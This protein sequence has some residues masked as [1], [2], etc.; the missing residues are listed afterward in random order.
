MFE[1][2]AIRL[3]FFISI[4]IL[5][6]SQKKK[7]PNNVRL[8]SCKSTLTCDRGGGC[9]VSFFTPS[10]G[11]PDCLC[12]SRGQSVEVLHVLGVVR[13]RHR[14]FAVLLPM[15]D[16]HDDHHP[17]C[18]QH[19]C[20]EGVVIRHLAAQGA[21]GQ[22]VVVE[23]RQ[24]RLHESSRE[25][26]LAVRVEVVPLLTDDQ[27]EAEFEFVPGPDEVAEILDLAQ[28]PVV[29]PGDLGAGGVEN[30]CG[31]HSFYFLPG[32]Y[33]LGGAKNT[34]ISAFLCYHK[35]VKKSILY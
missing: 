31:A 27:L 24:G 6:S 20:H 23:R 18:S 4:A 7:R 29:V 32:R 26:E 10:L 14:D 35:I 28:K 22:L 21:A 5:I 25:V 13:V 17:L 2:R 12:L 8:S 33:G 30:H 34:D 19:Q 16:L 11:S 9:S 15:E 1:F 3:F